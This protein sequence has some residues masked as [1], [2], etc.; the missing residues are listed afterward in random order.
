MKK[1]FTIITAVLLVSTAFGK[2]N[3]S[4][5]L[6]VQG[7]IK[8]IGVQQVFKSYQQDFAGVITMDYDKNFTYG[9]SVKA[10]TKNNV[11]F[12]AGLNLSNVSYT[13]RIH[14]YQSNP[15]QYTADRQDI[16]INLGVEKVFNAHDRVDIHLG[17]FAPIQINGKSEIT[18]VISGQEEKSIDFVTETTQAKPAIG[19]GMATGFNVEILKVLRVGMELQPTYSRFSYSVDNN[20]SEAIN[21]IKYGQFNMNMMLSVGVAW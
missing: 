4:E 13:N 7:T 5:R 3:I 8:T 21:D 20:N 17:A 18:S 10:Q 11:A 1:V 16:I 2:G 19:L 6:T 14:H 15:F 9:V 12:R